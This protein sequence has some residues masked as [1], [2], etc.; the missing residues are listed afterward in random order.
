MHRKLSWSLALCALVGLV[1]AGIAAAEKPITVEAGNLRLTFNGGVAPKALSKTKLEPIS[2]N[3][4]GK[5]ESV[6]GGHPPPLTE[7]VVDTDKNGTID[8]QGVPSCKQGQ[9][10]ARTTKDAEGVCG[11]AIL[12]TGTTDIEVLF[13]ESKPVTLHS[14]LLALNGGTKGGTTTI[15]VHAY[16]SSPVTAAVVTTVK[17]TK[18]H[19]GRYG[20]RSVAA[21]PKI[22]NYAGSVRA[23]S[24]TFKKKLFAYRGKKHGY[25]L[26][27]CPDGHFEAQAEAVFHDGTRLGPARVT[28]ACTP[29]G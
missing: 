12:G 14:K 13:A 10:E 28:R 27:K 24:L 23:F 18:E 2:L 16:L 7:L 1:A 19:K 15:F 4:Q 25:L 21:I 6:D 5:I 8:L 17:I 9:L 22:A 20:I 29:K 26:A 11:P 3:V